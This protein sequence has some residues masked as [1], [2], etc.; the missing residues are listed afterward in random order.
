[1]G[2][3]TDVLT[4]VYIVWIAAS[5]A[6]LAWAYRHTVKEKLCGDSKRA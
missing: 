6:A 5:M 1:M 3:S 4:I 2:V